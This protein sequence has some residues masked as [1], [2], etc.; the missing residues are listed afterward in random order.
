[1]QLAQLSGQLRKCE[2]I[3]G[4]TA[5]DP[6]GCC[7]GEVPPVHFTGMPVGK[8]LPRSAQSKGAAVKFSL[9]WST[10]WAAAR[11]GSKV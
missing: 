1:M 6:A 7:S 4:S 8:S 9:T 10:A 2:H 11:F 5:H 3:V